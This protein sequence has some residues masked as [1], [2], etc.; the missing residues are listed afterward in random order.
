MGVARC[1]LFR[2]AA[3]RSYRPSFGQEVLCVLIFCGLPPPSFPDRRV[4]PVFA[5]I[6]QE[7]SLRGGEIHMK[8]LMLLHK[9]SGLQFQFH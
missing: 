9:F 1:L 6:L 2:A 4:T 8:Q 5:A 7:V 3:L